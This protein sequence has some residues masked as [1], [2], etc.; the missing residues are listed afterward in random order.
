MLG[1]RI[2]FFLMLVAFVAVGAGAGWKTMGGMKTIRNIEAEIAKENATWDDIQQER[3]ELQESIDNEKDR[4]SE[5]PDS[6]QGMKNALAVKSSLSL[7]KVEGILQNKE[8]RVKKRLEHLNAEQAQA[9]ER[10]TGDLVK[11]GVV[12]IVLLAGLV[13][14]R[15]RMNRSR[16]LLA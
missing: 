4:L 12:E 1:R 10:L 5:L 11:L 9:R 15:Q 6:S 16:R 8:H 7:A 13:V 2:V 3:R 14:A